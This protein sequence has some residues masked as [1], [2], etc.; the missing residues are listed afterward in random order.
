MYPCFRKCLQVILQNV[1]EEVTIYSHSG[2]SVEKQSSSFAFLFS[3]ITPHGGESQ[4][5]RLLSPNAGA[6]QTNPLIFLGPKYVRWFQVLPFGPA[7]LSQELELF[8]DTA[9]PRAGK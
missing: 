4:D 6:R 9:M 8:P 1:T 3:E 7:F 5:L 2:N